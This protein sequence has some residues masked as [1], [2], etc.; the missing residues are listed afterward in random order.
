MLGSL[1]MEK[2]DFETAIKRTMAEEHYREVVPFVT[3][4]DAAF[5]DVDKAFAS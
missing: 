5:V 3:Q 4:V 2:D 1:R